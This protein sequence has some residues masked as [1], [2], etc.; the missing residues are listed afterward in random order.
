MLWYIRNDIPY[1]NWLNIVLSI[2]FRVASL[3]LASEKKW[4]FCCLNKNNSSTNLQVISNTLDSLIILFRQRF[5]LLK[6][7]SW[8][9]AN[10]LSVYN[11][12]NLAKQKTRFENPDNLSCYRLNSDWFLSQLSKHQHFWNGTLRFS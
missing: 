12:K 3:K 6:Q 4:L 7:K 1:Q 8:T 2:Y 10:F 5:S 9:M 11:L